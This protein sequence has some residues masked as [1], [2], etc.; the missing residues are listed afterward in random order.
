[1]IR[2]RFLSRKKTET[3]LSKLTESPLHFFGLFPY[4]KL[5]QLNLV[6]NRL[7]VAYLKIFNWGSMILD[8]AHSLLSPDT[9]PVVVLSQVNPAMPVVAHHVVGGPCEPLGASSWSLPPR[10]T[11]NLRYLSKWLTINDVNIFV[12]NLQSWLNT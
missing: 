12:C 2:V 7:W 4:E 10:I 3:R 1:M 6:F 9:G 8:A 5:S 11:S